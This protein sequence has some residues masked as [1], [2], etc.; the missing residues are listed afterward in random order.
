LLVPAAAN[1][2]LG[3]IWGNLLV[4][5]AVMGEAVFL[6]LRKTLP[7]NFS[8]L[9]VSGLLS[10]LGLVMFLP[11]AIWQ[12]LD[13]DFS[14]PDLGDWGAI[15]YFGAVFTVIG[16]ILW[17]RGVARVKGATAGAFSAVMPVSAVI[18][19]TVFLGEPFTWTHALGISLVLSSI[20]LLTRAQGGA[21]NMEEANKPVQ[22]SPAPVQCE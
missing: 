21:E 9:T 17:F 6:L 15:A 19:S 5:G 7:P 20:A 11:L 22:P 8:S 3:H 18:L 14:K 10:M 2:P 13:F 1:A 16:Y 4:L 12:G